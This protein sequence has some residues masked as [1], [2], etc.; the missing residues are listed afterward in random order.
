MDISSVILRL[1]VIDIL[2]QIPEKMK[3]WR[4]PKPLLSRL[5]PE[6][7]NRLS[8]QMKAYLKSKPSME[9]DADKTPIISKDAHLPQ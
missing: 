8:F 9:A 3:N 1:M 7:R 2:K 6:Q 4:A 5:T